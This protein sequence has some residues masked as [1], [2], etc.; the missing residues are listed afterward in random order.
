M[1]KM[2]PECHEEYTLAATRCADCDV[3]LVDCDE[4]AQEEELESFPPAS[5]HWPCSPVSLAWQAVRAGW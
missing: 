2:C 1:P 4:F 3:Y 5:E